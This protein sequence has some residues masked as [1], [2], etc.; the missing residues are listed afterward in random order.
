MNDIDIKKAK[1]AELYQ[2]YANIQPSYYNGVEGKNHLA[3]NFADFQTDVMFAFDTSRSD[4]T[5]KNGTIDI[6]LEI[7]ASENF[8][9]E[10][11]AFC[12]IIYENEFTYS[13]ADGLV[14]RRV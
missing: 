7:K 3:N 9:T 11:T 1:Y 4:E 8:P 14:E 10:V 2:S 5:L 6:R 12:L 13:P